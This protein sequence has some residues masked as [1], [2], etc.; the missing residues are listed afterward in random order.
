NESKTLVSQFLDCTGHFVASSDK[1]KAYVVNRLFSTR[2]FVGYKD[3]IPLL[4]CQNDGYLTGK[5][6]SL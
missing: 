2:D 3:S 6:P 4:F 1:D 5:K